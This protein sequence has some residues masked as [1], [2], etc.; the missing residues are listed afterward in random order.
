M[1]HSDDEKEGLI[2]NYIE[3]DESE[4]NNDNISNKSNNSNDS[5]NNCPI[6]LEL[7]IEDR[8]TTPCNHKFHK[9][10]IQN[11]INQSNIRLYCICPICRRKLD[12]RD[13]LNLDINNENDNL[14]INNENNE[15]SIEEVNL[16]INYMRSFRNVS[17]ILGFIQLLSYIIPKL[18][19]ENLKN[20]KCYNTSYKYYFIGIIN[21]IIHIIW[22]IQ[23]YKFINYV[24]IRRIEYELFNK[25]RT[26]FKNLG[27]TIIVNAMTQLYYYFSFIEYYNSIANKETFENCGDFYE[28][29]YWI[30]MSN[31]GSYIMIFITLF[32]LMET[33]RF[34]IIFFNITNERT[35]LLET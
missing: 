32:Y 26:K 23:S 29:K 5:V 4:L 34:D 18:I 7:V 21:I 11:Y 14:D 16:R 24:D 15:I 28:E 3:T 19:Y 10:C 33:K 13:L 8:L 30:L 31:F 2:L 22:I 9:Q 6:C 1:I 12:M 27:L 35:Q 17:Y 20:I 25:I